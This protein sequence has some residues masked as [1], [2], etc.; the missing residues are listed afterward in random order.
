MNYTNYLSDF[1]NCPRQIL[2]NKDNN[3]IT[4]QITIEYVQI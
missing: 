3:K 1:V 2:H 4:N